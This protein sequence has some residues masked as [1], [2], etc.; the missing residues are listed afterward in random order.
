M[1][2]FEDAGQNPSVCNLHRE[3]LLSCVIDALIFNL[4]TIHF[5]F[6]RCFL[7]EYGY[8]SRSAS[9]RKHHILGFQKI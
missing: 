6:H 7:A 4:A 9:G 2:C 1:I 8:L 5:V 3:M